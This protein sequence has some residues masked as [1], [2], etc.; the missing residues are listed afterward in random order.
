MS[1]NQNDNLN[2]DEK[3][4]KIKAQKQEDAF[5]PHDYTKNLMLGTRSRE[6]MLGGIPLPGLFPD[7]ED[8]KSD[9]SWV[10]GAIILEII[11]LS[12]LCYALW[13]ETTLSMNYVVLIGLII[14]F[15]DVVFAWLHH[16]TVKPLECKI[17]NEKMRITYDLRH[18]G[19][20]L[21]YLNYITFLEKKMPSWRKV[22]SLIAG[23]IIILLALSKA[24]VFTIHLPQTWVDQIKLMVL[25][26]CILSYGI[27][28]YIH[29][30]KTGF[31]IAYFRYKR[32]WIKDDNKFYRGIQ[33]DS[34]SFIRQPNQKEIDLEK[35]V[36]ELKDVA[37]GYSKFKPLIPKDEDV[38]KKQIEKGLE[39]N[40]GE[41]E[42]IVKPHKI[43]QKDNSIYEIRTLGR[44]TDDE[45][46][47]M[48]K[49][50]PEGLAKT[51]VALYGHYLQSEFI[52]FK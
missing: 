21:S 20:A 26:P 10:I 48:V 17:E 44:L 19:Q 16:F 25:I 1:E 36:D 42:K 14:I 30:A 40:M 22:V 2:Q 12:C 3:E 15:I 24:I 23:S 41:L 39:T 34:T 51:A 50:Q 43:V 32:N 37:N 8:L 9:V 11:G 4:Q 7:D 5:E 52:A 27:V 28:A 46:E 38:V 18:T 13:E 35:F 31:L 6:R 45:L 29:I 47:A 33:D 49:V